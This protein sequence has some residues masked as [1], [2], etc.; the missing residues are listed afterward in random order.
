MKCAEQRRFLGSPGARH[1]PERW[2]SS[3]NNA[4]SGQNYEPMTSPAGG[5]ALDDGDEARWQRANANHNHLVTLQRGTELQKALRFLL[6]RSCSL[7]CLVYAFNCCSDL[8][9]ATEPLPSFQP[10][11][12]HIHPRRGSAKLNSFLGSVIF[13]N[14]RQASFSFTTTT[15]LAYLEANNT[16]LSP[17]T[18]SYEHGVKD[19][20]TSRQRL[21]AER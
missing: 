4:A 2:L 6:V 3:A 9:S 1:P 19:G 5:D 10:T 18:N 20:Y 7:F 11:Y 17:R 12:T 16:P 15:W 13:G 14:I 8:L 21:D